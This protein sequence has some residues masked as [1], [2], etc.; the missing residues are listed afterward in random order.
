METVKTYLESLAPEVRAELDIVRDVVLKNLPKGYEEVMQYGIIGYVVPLSA[1]PAGYLGKKD[2]PLP[3]ASLAAR[4]NENMIALMGLYTDSSLM[5]WFVDE[6]D[7][8]G[9]KLKMGKS[10]IY[11]KKADDLA[12]GVIGKAV[13]KVSVSDYVK[14]YE[15]S[16]KR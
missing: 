7:K 8:S 15:A 6:Y 16:R 12:L 5:D 1:Y 14:M 4:K 10:C 13:A 9:K 2:Q 11:F 3:Y